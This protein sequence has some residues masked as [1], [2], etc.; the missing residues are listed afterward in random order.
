MEG[1]LGASEDYI[2]KLVYL[3]YGPLWLY[4]VS[5]FGREITNLKVNE[6]L[7]ATDVPVLIVQGGEDKQ[8]PCHKYSIYY[9]RDRI[10]LWYKFY[11]Y[12]ST[13]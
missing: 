10:I 4:Q 6:I 9:A 12:G 7:S 2:G 13:W 1:I 3:N 5:L 8:F 11:L